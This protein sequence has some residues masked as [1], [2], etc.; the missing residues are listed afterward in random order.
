MSTWMPGEWVVYSK[1]KNSTVPGPR[2]KEVFPATAGDTY[3]YVV[4][5]Y[6]VID[7]VLEEG[8]VQ[9]RTR[10]GKQHLINADDPRLRPAR[11]WERLLLAN[12]FPVSETEAATV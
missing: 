5:K 8:L 10:R 4:D 11:W 3:S 6:W 2:A 12:R 1:Q 7:N 9:L